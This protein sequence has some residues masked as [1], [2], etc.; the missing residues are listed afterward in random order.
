VK[1]T[2]VIYEIR[3][4]TVVPGRMPTLVRL[5]REH[6]L[7]LFERHGIEVVFISLTEVGDNSVNE[8]V[9][10]L[11]FDSYAEF[12]KRWAAFNADPD[13]LAA[14]TASQEGGANVASV[15]RRVLNP[16]VFG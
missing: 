13:W 15:R 11:K 16:A 7:R 8:L 12:G 10:V 6:A 14:R 2:L 4:Y 5:F 3:E 9:Y 1:G